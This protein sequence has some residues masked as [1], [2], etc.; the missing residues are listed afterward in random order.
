MG[1]FWR[2]YAEIATT[3]AEHIKSLIEAISQETFE[4]DGLEEKTAPIYDVV[5]D[6]TSVFFTSNGY[7][8]YGIEAENPGPLLFEKLFGCFDGALVCFEYILPCQSQGYY[9]SSTWAKAEGP[10]DWEDQDR[11][12]KC[13]RIVLEEGELGEDYNEF[14]EFDTFSVWNIPLDILEKLQLHLPNLFQMYVRARENNF[15]D[16]VMFNDTHSITY[17][18]ASELAEE[19]VDDVDAVIEDCIKDMKQDIREHFVDN[20]AVELPKNFPE[21]KTSSYYTLTI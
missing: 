10:I 3:E 8:C 11:F 20:L 17:N 15:E 14:D 2:S 19:Y 4:D 16:W 21:V 5:I 12:D 1:V 7:G 6:G 18:L 9:M 13:C